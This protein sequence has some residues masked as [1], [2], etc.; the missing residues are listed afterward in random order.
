MNPILAAM[1]TKI[2]TNVATNVISRKIL[3]DPE[4]PAQIGFGT[5]PTPRPG[6]SMDIDLPEGSEFESLLEDSNLD[7][8]ELA[9]ILQLLSDKED[10]PL[11]LA[12]GGDVGSI[13]PYE[14]S[15]LEKQRQGIAS[16]IMKNAPEEGFLSSY[17]NPY[18]ANELAEKITFLS[19]F[20]PGFGD[21]QSVREGEYMIEEGNSL[22]GGIMM[23]AGVLPFIPGTPLAKLATKLQQK[24][25]QGKFNEQRELRNAASGDGDAGYNAAERHRKSWQKDQRKLDEMIAKEKAT[26]NLEPKVTPKEPPK[27]VQGELNL[28]PKQDLLFH[29]SQTKELPNLELPK[30]QGTSEGGIYTLV[31]PTDPRFKQYA[32]GKP[33][34]GGPGSGYVLQPNFEKTLDIDNMPDSVL[35]KLQN[36]E[37]YRGRPSR[38]GSEKLDFDLNTI[39]RGDKFMSSKTPTNINTELSDIFTKEGYDALRFPK[40]NMTGEAETVISL[41]PSKLD[42]VNEIPYEDLDDFIRTFLND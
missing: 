25:K 7:E 31:T 36:L 32:F 12:D 6:P 15:P 27:V 35:N 22:G 1:L 37:M 21:V 13:T 23:G 2:G 42:I 29:G 8:E 4:Y 17:K 40:R 33:S 9:L 34:R 3:G 11:G 28:Q 41:D 24:I 18:Q 38:L 16:F 30:G 10:T 19:E 26:P 39:L 20:I 5:D 14:P